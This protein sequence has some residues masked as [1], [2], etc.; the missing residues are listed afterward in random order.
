MRWRARLV[1]ASIGIAS[2]WSVA[3]DAGARAPSQIGWWWV[4]RAAGLQT[5]PPTDV[6]D[7]GLYVAADPTGAQ[8]ISALRFDLGA[9]V[10][11]ITLRLRVSSS[12][13][14]PL[15][16]ACPSAARWAP[17]EGGNWE[18]RPAAACEDRA[19]PATVT[20]AEVTFDA[21]SLVHDGVLDVV[22]VPARDPVLGPMAATFSLA[23]DP[24]GEHSLDIAEPSSASGAEQQSADAS[25]GVG[26]AAGSPTPS[27]P[28]PSGF[29]PTR[30]PDPSVAISGSDVAGRSVVPAP[31]RLAGRRLASGGDDAA[32]RVL[33]LLLLA[34]LGL[35]AVAVLTKGRWLGVPFTASHGDADDGFVGGIGEF[36][37][38]RNGSPPSVR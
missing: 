5:P 13:G 24:P 12:T 37:R 3:P 18:E 15:M 9:G 21:A 31:S 7:G 23:L 20:E 8:A 17:A 27:I 2:A 25:P 1:V 16:L 29:V 35:I 30:G 11:A 6:P 33:G 36:R 19:V 26:G 38:I 28:V 34:S 22:I 14:T 4:G 10:D 32:G